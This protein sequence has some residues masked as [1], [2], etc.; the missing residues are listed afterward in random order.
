MI[1]WISA[2]SWID[3]FCWASFAEKQIVDGIAAACRFVGQQY[4]AFLK[5][6]ELFCDSLF[7]AR[8]FVVHNKINVIEHDSLN[9]NK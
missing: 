9:D 2:H 7:S 1:V 8:K 5:I 6:Q 4:S 3:R